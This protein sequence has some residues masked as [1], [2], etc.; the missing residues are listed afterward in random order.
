MRFHTA[1][2]LDFS[3]LDIIVIDDNEHT[4]A[5]LETIL[6][7]FRVARVRTYLSAEDA[8][9]DMETSPPNLLIIDW[10]MR[11]ADGCK[12]VEQIRKKS[13]TPLCFLPVLLVTA[14]SSHKREEQAH[15]SGVNQFIAKPVSP[16][17][18]YQSICKVLTDRRRIIRQGEKYVI[19]TLQVEEAPRKVG[20]A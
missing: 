8:L 18:I 1:Y 6:T 16:T 13:M 14:Y 11:S 2:G 17:K 5:I 7:A 9:L 12:F 15:R 19:E 4:L 3:Q 20:V 10:A